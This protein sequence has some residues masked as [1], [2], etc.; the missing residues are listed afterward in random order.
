M[1]YGGVGGRMILKYIIEE[2]V[3]EGVDWIDLVEDDKW[4]PLLNT[5]MKF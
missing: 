5:V 3:Y 2:I 4:W 1:E